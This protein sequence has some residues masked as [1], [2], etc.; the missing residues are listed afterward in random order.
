MTEENEKKGNPKTEE[1]D[2]PSPEETPNCPGGKIGS[3]GR[4]RGDGPGPGQGRGRGGGRGSGRGK[5]RGG[6]R[7]RQG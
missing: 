4:G 5:G 2:P 1:K 7:R 3:G 6:D